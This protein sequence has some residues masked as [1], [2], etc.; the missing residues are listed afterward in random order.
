MSSSGRCIET[1]TWIDRKPRGVNMGV[2]S[3]VKLSQQLPA[4]LAGHA[5]RFDL[6]THAG[7]VRGEPDPAS[8]TAKFVMV[9]IEL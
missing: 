3:I 4:P 2:Y 9:A 5:S 7:S 6:C 1:G 8:Q